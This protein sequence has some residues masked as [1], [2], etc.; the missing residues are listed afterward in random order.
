MEI[1]FRTAIPSDVNQVVPLTYSCGEVEFIY[2]LTMP[3]TGPADFL[4]AAFLGGA[5]EYGHK[6]FRVAA[7]DGKVAGICNA[8]SGFK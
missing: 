7:V 6:A 5:G 4:R 8:H 2:F 3:Q 1:Q